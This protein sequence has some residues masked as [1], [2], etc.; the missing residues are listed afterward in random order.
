[1]RRGVDLEVLGPEVEREAG[2]AGERLLERA[3]QVDLERVAVTVGL[4]LLGAELDEAPVVGGH[5]NH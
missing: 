1:V 5:R 2:A 4:G 3:H